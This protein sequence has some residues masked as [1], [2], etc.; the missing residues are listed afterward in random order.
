MPTMMCSW[1]AK[2]PWL[3]MRFSWRKRV[4]GGIALLWGVMA[5]RRFRATPSQREESIIPPT[6]E[7]PMIPPTGPTVKLKRAPRDLKN[8]MARDRLPGGLGL[9]G[10][11]SAS[12][13]RE[14]HPGDPGW[15]PDPADPEDS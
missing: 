10:I 5:R 12:D 8:V 15:I 11:T 1:S 6:G 14:I 3:R 4:T 13:T 9:V 2:L 7:K